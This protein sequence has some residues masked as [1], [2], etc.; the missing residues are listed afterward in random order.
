M[1]LTQPFLKT[2]SFLL[3]A[4]FPYKEVNTR[5]LTFSYGLHVRSNTY[6]D[7][8]ISFKKSEV[9]FGQNAQANLSLNQK[10]GT[11]NSTI[12]YSNYFKDAS[13]NNL[14]A[15]LQFNIRITGGLSMYLYSSGA[16]VRDQIYLVKG[17]ASEQDVLT[18]RWQ[19]ASSYNFYSGFGLNFRFGSKLNNFVNPRLGNL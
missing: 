3:Y 17:K 2:I 14:S 15:K 4:L 19:I 13:L 8:T 16:R 9:L 18:R 5:L 12:A 7:T 10:W 6:N 11:I 1:Q